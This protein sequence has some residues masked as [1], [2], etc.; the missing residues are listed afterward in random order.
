MH[1]RMRCNGTCFVLQYFILKK[2]HNVSGGHTKKERQS[3]ALNRCQEVVTACSFLMLLNES[4][5]RQLQLPDTLTTQVFV[6]LCSH[7][8]TPEMNVAVS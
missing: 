5:I 4:V 1:G 2:A 3:C 7:S 8:I 6:Q